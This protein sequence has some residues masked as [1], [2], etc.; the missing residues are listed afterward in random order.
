MAGDQPAGS[1]RCFADYS[2][3]FVYYSGTNWCV[4]SN[5]RSATSRLAVDKQADRR[6]GGAAAATPRSLTPP[7]T[8]CSGKS[9]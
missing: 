2:K 6:T 7:S 3:G 1:V 9:T 5:S 8:S 4:W